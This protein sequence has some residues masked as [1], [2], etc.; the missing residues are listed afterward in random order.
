[1]SMT[2]SPPGTDTHERVGVRWL[3][4][5]AVAAV[6]LVL[7]LPAAALSGATAPLLLADAGPLVRWGQI[8]SGVVQTVAAA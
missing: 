2:L 5:V 6:A 3:P 8:V 7:A 4:A 1:M